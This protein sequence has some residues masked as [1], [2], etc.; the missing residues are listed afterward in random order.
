MLQRSWWFAEAGARIINF[1]S[2]RKNNEIEL[3]VLALCYPGRLALGSECG[4]GHY[5]N[6]AISTRSL[7][8]TLS[9]LAPIFS[10]QHSVM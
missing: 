4:R 8:L 9:A 10:F 7:S 3:R 6:A 2:I 5:A 1:S